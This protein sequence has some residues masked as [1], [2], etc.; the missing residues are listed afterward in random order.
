MAIR[1]LAGSF[2]LALPVWVD[3][4]EPSWQGKLIVLTRAGVKLEAPEGKN[5]APKSAG[6]AKDLMFQVRQEDKDRLLIDSRRQEGWIAR[7]DAIPFDQARAHFTKLIESNPKNVH[8][9]MAR[10]AVLSSSNEPD[11]AVADFTSAIEL[12]AKTT[13]AYYHRAN[14]AYGK[15]Q[16]D[17]AL[18]DYNAVVEQDPEFDW[19]YHVRGWIYY[20][21]MDY[22]KAVAD[23][24]TAIKLVPTETVFYRDRGNV[25]FIRKK[26]DDALKDYSKSIEMDPTYVV[27]WQMRGKTWEA[28]KEYAKALADYEK[29]ATLAPT[30]MYG[31]GYHTTVAMLLAACPDAKIR[32]G[33]KALAA[34]QKAYVLAQGANE[35][36]TLAAA[37]AELG[38]FD[39]AVEWQTKALAAVP[40][41]LKE[42][43]QQ[44]LKLY[45][46]KKPYRMD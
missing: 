15:G 40:A 43:Y 32:D 44:R 9:L 41:L 8:A 10:G 16:Y 12:D 4:A 45:E 5:I 22:D 1:W 6:V 18:A 27:P 13:L 21:R 36:A 35:L 30:G 46:D 25:A 38:E 29:A 17:K 37:H 24:E 28:K 31:A 42:Q 2:L 11:K 7:S 20:R 33:K 26:Y 34:A 19:A 39:K 3:A 23:Y 14:V